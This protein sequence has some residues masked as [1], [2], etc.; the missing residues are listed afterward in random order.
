MPV[1]S[2]ITLST[3][4]LGS[5]LAKFAS[6]FCKTLQLKDLKPGRGEYL[7]TLNERWRERFLQH[8]SEPSFRLSAGYE[9]VP[10]TLVG[11][12]VE[13]DSA[14][15]FAQQTQGFLKDHSHVAKPT[16][17][18]DPLYLWVQQQLLKKA[19]DPG[20]HQYTDA[21]VERLKTV[22]D[23]M[24]K[25]LA[26]T[27]LE[28]ALKLINQGEIKQARALLK[29][30]EKK[31]DTEILKIAKIKFATAQTYDL[32]LDYKNAFRYYE[33]SARLAPDNSLYQNEAGFMANILGQYDKAIGYFEKAL[34]S[35]LATF[36]PD[37]PDVA[38]YWNNLGLAWNS[39]GEYDKA[40]GYYE[41]AVENFRNN[42]G[43]A[44]PNVATGW[45][46]L[47]DTWEKK[48]DYNRAIDYYQK[49]L[50]VFKK[51]GLNHRVEAVEKFL[52]R[53]LGKKD[54]QK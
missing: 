45:W 46:N 22:I 12:I 37:H 48:D 42:L 17:E 40:I 41:K 36:G 52:E 30:N 49:A 35:G 26:G 54:E 34:A 10:I 5:G 7:D 25:D 1:K 32:E 21:E 15:Y 18:N 2:V 43:K 39:K 53:A 8:D 51:A 13:K 28:E 16:G 50:V 6:F 29:K 44:H 3:P 19:S 23:Q 14:V 24:Q 27:D 47:G 31:Q 4:N 11:R 9:I 33:T 20:V 38:T